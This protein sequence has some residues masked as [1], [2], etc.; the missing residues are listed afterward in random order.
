MVAFGEKAWQTCN[1][2]VRAIKSM[3]AAGIPTG[4]ENR[5]RAYEVAVKNCMGKG[6]IEWK[7]GEKLLSDLSNETVTAINRINNTNKDKVN[8]WLL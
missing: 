7:H 3:R 6:K 4:G 8:V 1:A 2:I 5:V